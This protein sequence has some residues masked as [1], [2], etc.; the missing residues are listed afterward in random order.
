MR[1]H[2]L[3]INFE[4]FLIDGSR[5]IQLAA[6]LQGVSLV[7]HL[8]NAVFP[9]RIHGVEERVGVV[10]T[11]RGVRSLVESELPG[12]PGIAP[13]RAKCS[14]KRVERFSVVRFDC[15]AL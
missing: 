9:N 12:R 15:Q 7:E 1:L 11:R 2:V 13:Q 5:S 8:L 3:G 6:S 14:R 4:D 10:A